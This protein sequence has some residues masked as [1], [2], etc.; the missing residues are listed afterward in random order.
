MVAYR[1]IVGADGLKD[2]RHYCESISQ[3]TVIDSGLKEADFPFSSRTV[4]HAG[5]RSMNTSVDSIESTLSHS[6]SLSNDSD[7]TSHFDTDIMWPPIGPSPQEVASS[8]KAEDGT[9]APSTPGSTLVIRADEEDDSELQMENSLPK[10][11]HL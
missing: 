11:T 1:D 3:S 6:G 5:F 4:P 2:L 7:I 9:K 10:Q 8:K